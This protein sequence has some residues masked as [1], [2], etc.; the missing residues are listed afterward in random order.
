MNTTH[1][2]LCLIPMLS[3]V[4]VCTPASAATQVFS[5]TGAAAATEFTNF[6][7]AI[8][9]ATSVAGNKISW[10]GV[11]LDGTDANPKTRVIDQGK[12]VEI[13]VDRFKNVGAIFADP[14]TVSGDGFASVNPA[15]A[16]QFPAFSPKNTFAMF[17]PNDGQ[18]EDRNIQQSFVLP[19]TDTA[20]GT[21]GFGVIFVDVEK[22]HSSSIEYFGKDAYNKKV[23]I[24]KYYVKPS[25]NGE[26]QFLGVLYDSAVIAEI[27]ITV[28]SKALFSF[29]GKTVKSFGAENL[30]KKIDLVVTDDFFFALPE[31]LQPSKDHTPLANCF[32]DWAERRYGSYFFPTG[33]TTEVSAPDIYRHYRQNDVT[34][35]VSSNDEHVYFQSPHGDMQDVGPASYWY[36]LAKCDKD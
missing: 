36:N 3:S 17:D 33:A 25:V 30:A 26:A 9:N 32:F 13:P 12:T 1:K 27:E 18:F 31:Q 24:G 7:T 23:S 22:K 34:L 19:N 29:D 14:Y 16:G 8:K 15:T 10:D 5:G 2:L 20:A 21:R 35:G 4:M 6:Q 28:G 11:K